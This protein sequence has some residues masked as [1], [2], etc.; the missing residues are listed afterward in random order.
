MAERL[1][2]IRHGDLG[3]RR[4]GRYIGRTD[5]PLSQEGRR[6]AAALAGP[7]VRRPDVASVLVSPLRRTRETAELAL[8]RGANFV[9]DPDLREIDFGRW[10]G[11][12][13][14]KI[15]AA[16]PAAVDRWAALADNFAFP[17]GESIGNFRKRIGAAARRIAADPA[18]TAVVVTHG[19]VIRFLICHFL[20]LP[21]R[22]HLLFDVQPASI[23]EIRIDGGKGVLTLLN[24]RRHLEIC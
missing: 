3:A 24:D 21:D 12:G 13:F 4:R 8:G 9:V 7:L 19:G 23:S 2:L 18:R 5:A 11:M 15:L 6:Q 17:E 22:A 16:D 10:E 20:G 14:A 1:I